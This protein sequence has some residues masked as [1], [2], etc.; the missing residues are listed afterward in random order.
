MEC[1]NPSIAAL[2]I[3]HPQ[4]LHFQHRHGNAKSLPVK[5]PRP[6]Q[7]APLP[8]IYDEECAINEAV[9]FCSSFRECSLSNVNLSIQD[10]QS[11]ISHV[12]IKLKELSFNNFIFPVNI[13]HPPS[14]I[15]FLLE[16]ER[17]SRHRQIFSIELPRRD[18][19]RTFIRMSLPHIS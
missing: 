8:L 13:N 6:G 16:C 18:K 14:P 1:R 11:N 10:C 2:K 7:M 3:R 4:F 15:C 5:K 17:S 12:I 9:T 19:G